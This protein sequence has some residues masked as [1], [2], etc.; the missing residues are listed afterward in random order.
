MRPDRNRIRHHERRG[1]YEEAIKVC[2]FLLSYDE[3]RPVWAFGERTLER[4]PLARHAANILRLL[5]QKSGYENKLTGFDGIRCSTCLYPETRSLQDPDCVCGIVP[6]PLS[7]YVKALTIHSP[8]N[9]WV[10]LHNELC[11]CGEK[12]SPSQNPPKDIGNRIFFKDSFVYPN[13]HLTTGTKCRRLLPEVPE[14]LKL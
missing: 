3:W 14:I 13:G 6:N 11:E 9:W 1:E 4:I 7:L 12:Y 8:Q 10:W 2:S 5:S